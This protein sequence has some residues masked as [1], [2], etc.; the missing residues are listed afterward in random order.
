MGGGFGDVLGRDSAKS[1]P[2]ARAWL[3]V[4]KGTFETQLMP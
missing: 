1:F 2:L 3:S 4:A